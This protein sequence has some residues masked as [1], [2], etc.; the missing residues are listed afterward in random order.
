MHCIWSK[1][2]KKEREDEFQKKEGLAFWE[3]QF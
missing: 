2:E 3:K 1:E